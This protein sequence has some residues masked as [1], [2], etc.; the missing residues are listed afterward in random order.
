MLSDNDCE[1]SR[2]VSFEPSLNWLVMLAG[3]PPSKHDVMQIMKNTDRVLAIDGGASILIEYGVVPDI[4]IGDFDSIL[5]KDLGYLREIDVPLATFK[6]D[7]DFTD[8]ELGLKFLLSMKAS[9]A[10][11]L[12]ASDGH[13]DHHLANY[14]AISLDAFRSINLEILNPPFR[15]FVVREGNATNIEGN[16]GDLVSIIPLSDEVDIELFSGVKWE[17]DNLKIMRGEARTLRN[18]LSSS[19]ATLLTTRGKSIVV[20]KYE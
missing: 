3:K 9:S 14:M 4:A 8:L 17:V 11:I 15:S 2:D 1:S 18:Q 20:H 13:P 12:G 19:S 6:S 10:K 16:P 5:P 7:K